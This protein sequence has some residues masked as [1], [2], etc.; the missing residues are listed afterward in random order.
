MSNPRT[1]DSLKQYV[2]SHWTQEE[3]TTFFRD[4]L[5]TQRHML[6]AIELRDDQL[7]ARE[8]RDG[9]EHLALVIALVE[10]KFH[11]DPRIVSL[12]YDYLNAEPTINIGILAMLDAR[13]HPT[14][15]QIKGRV[16]SLSAE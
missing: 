2:R 11:G 1:F 6:N 3:Q 15:S 4:I 8:L 14:V 10:K 9:V 12:I 13:K 16:T 5:W 7:I